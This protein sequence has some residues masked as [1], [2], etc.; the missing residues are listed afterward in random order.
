MPLKLVLASADDIPELVAMRTRVSQDLAKK[1]SGG[2]GGQK[3][4]RTEF[5][6]GIEGKEHSLSHG[7][8]CNRHCTRKCGLA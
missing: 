8:Y 7:P 3:R 6:R 5:G 4:N 1:F 2:G